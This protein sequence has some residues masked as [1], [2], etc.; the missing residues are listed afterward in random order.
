[1]AAITGKKGTVTY[2]GGSVATINSWSLD[3][4]TNMHD[5]TSFTT[6]APTWRTF[7][8]GL[9][10]WS[11]SMD[12]TFDNASTGQKDLITNTL[13]PV[14]ADVIFELDQIVGGK[15]SGSAYVQSGS[16]SED[17]D[18]LADVSWSFQGTGALAY[19]TTT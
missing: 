5:V 17:I 3:V 14:A 12:G 15:F 19:T 8:D 10:G 4:D 2:D 1:M 13:V 11:G 16:F 6:A 18:G 9:S 7:V